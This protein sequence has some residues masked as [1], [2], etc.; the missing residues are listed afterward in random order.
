MGTIKA[1][2][3]VSAVSDVFPMIEYG[4]QKAGRDSVLE[5]LQGDGQEGA[6]AGDQGD[7]WE[8]REWAG[9]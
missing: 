1:E 4:T 6:A 3:I 9:R 8:P 7:S 2:V 5:E